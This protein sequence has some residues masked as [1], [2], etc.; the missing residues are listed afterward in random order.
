MDGI[1]DS[2]RDFL[3]ASVAVGGGL[4]VGFHVPAA[5]QFAQSGPATGQVRMNTFIRIAPDNTVTVMVGQSEMG[6]GVLTSIPMLVAEELEV[7]WSQIRV[8]QGLNDPAFVNPRWAGFKA[9]GGFQATTGS[10]A[11]RNVGTVVRPAAGAARMM[12][13]DAAAQTWSVPVDA[14]YAQSGRVIHRDSGRTLSYG[15]LATKAA[16]L[17]VPKDVPLKKPA[18]FKLLG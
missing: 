14:C 1:N 7:D 15:E 17:P 6:Q 11:I 16:A 3:K 13:V 2:R 5:G 9:K 8:E 10:S 12:L 18:D 4:I